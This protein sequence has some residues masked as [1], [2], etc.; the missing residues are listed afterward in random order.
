MKFIFVFRY[1]SHDTLIG[2]MAAIRNL[3]ECPFYDKKLWHRVDIENVLL[4]LNSK[5]RFPHLYPKLAAEIIANIRQKSFTEC[6]EELSRINDAK[7]ILDDETCYRNLFF[8][9]F[10]VNKP[11]F[12]EYDQLI[13]HDCLK[14]F[15]NVLLAYLDLKPDWSSSIR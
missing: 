8:I 4:R 12:N 6:L 7:K 9:K 13:K 5:S 11:M 1:E 15:E 10:V 3:T 2:I 14:M